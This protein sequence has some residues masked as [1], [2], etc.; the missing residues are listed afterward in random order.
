MSRRNLSTTVAGIGILSAVAIPLSVAFVWIGQTPDPGKMVVVGLDT[1]D[2]GTVRDSRRVLVHDFT[3]ENRT[4]RTQR[5]LDVKMNCG[6]LD[7]QTSSREI[8]PGK[9]VRVAVS[10]D[11]KQIVGTKDAVVFVVFEDAHIAPVRLEVKAYLEPTYA[12]RL[13][14][15]LIIVPRDLVPG[16]QGERVVK[17]T[18][19]LS[20]P[21]DYERD[22]LV[23]IGDSE[24]FQVKRIKPWTPKGWSFTRGYVR[25]TEMT[26]RYIVPSRRNSANMDP[27]T[28]IFTKVGDDKRPRKAT[29]VEFALARL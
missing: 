2:F 15:A 21:D 14:P 16:T 19:Y 1:V 29:S 4:E 13:E 28:M 27:V 9:Q 25:S 11:A 26:L 22:T 17:V 10:M 20:E 12:V 18:E 3:L 24:N 8:P 5:I 6:C 23:D 7:A